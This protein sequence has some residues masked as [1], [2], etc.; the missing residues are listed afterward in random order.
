[1]V[2]AAETID[3]HA[4]GDTALGR[5]R[6]RCRD[7]L[8]GLVITEN[9]GLEVDFT[10]RHV[11]GLLQRR[12]VVRAIAQQLQLVAVDEF[13]RHDNSIKRSLQYSLTQAGIWS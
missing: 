3:Q 6:E 13:R 4:H 11:D 2:L 7:S 12:K 5:A 8:P 1:M 9:V 10:L